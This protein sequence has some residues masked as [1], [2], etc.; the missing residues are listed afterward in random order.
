LG[1]AN[2]ALLEKHIKSFYVTHLYELAN[3]FFDRKTED[4]LF[5]RAERKADGTRTFKLLEGQPFKTSYGK[6]LYRW[7]FHLDGQ[8]QKEQ[9]NGPSSATLG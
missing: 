9:T 1:R 4:A 6:G 2:C 7:I 8:I 5:L 3:R